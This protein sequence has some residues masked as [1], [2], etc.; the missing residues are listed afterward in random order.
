MTTLPTPSR[1]RL[2]ELF[3]ELVRIPSP[4]RGERK[5]ADAVI[6]TLETLGV[7]V[8][9][10]ETAAA[11]KGDCGNLYCVVGEEGD[12]PCLA[13][14]AHLDT[15]TPPDCIDPVLD[16]EGVFRNACGGILGADDKVA[17]AALLHA[18]ELLLRSG[19][20]FPAYELFFTVCE[21]QGLVGAKHLGEGSLRSP[22]AVVLD[23]SGPVG[24]IV[25]RAPSQ[26]IIR[27][28]FKGRAAHAGLE[29]ELG[30]SAIQAAARAVAAMSLGRLDGETTAN[31]GTIKGGVATNVVPEVCELEGECRGHDEKRLADV[32]AAMVDAIQQAAVETGVDVEVNLVHEFHSFSLDEDSALVAMTKAAMSSA[33]LVPRLLTAGGGSDANV[34][35]ARGIP[36][37]NL[38]AG[39][40]RVH[41]AEENLALD[42]L[43]KLCEVALQLIAIAG[44]GQPK[45][46]RSSDVA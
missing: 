41:S 25:T 27:A 39:M 8:C 24:G 30:R 11:I 43:E 1:D 18:T 46:N 26:K 36:T 13:I 6:G 29:P 7:A 45:T 33:G 40:M 14:G 16:V 44:A 15:V 42:E 28:R 17:I 20:P 35:N 5:V 22:I 32:S 19:R 34:L 3:V 4:S 10:D 12:T 21:E 2:A 23:S 38:D 31:I 9:E 37:V